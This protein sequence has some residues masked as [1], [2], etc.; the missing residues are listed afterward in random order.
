MGPRGTHERGPA[1]AILRVDV[2]SYHCQ[3]HDNLEALRTRMRPSSLHSPDEHPR[4][5]TIMLA[6][7]QQ[8]LCRGSS[9]FELTMVASAL[10]DSRSFTLL[11]NWPLNNEKPSK[12][13]HHL[14][15]PHTHHTPSSHQ[16]GSV[17][18]TV[19]AIYQAR[20]CRRE[21]NI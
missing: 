16:Q 3:R 7:L 1:I 15:H 17:T 18:T 6:S 10:W 5:L 13:T 20:C 4:R 8:A 19:L 21:Q 11:A 14:S 9:P 2:W 12:L